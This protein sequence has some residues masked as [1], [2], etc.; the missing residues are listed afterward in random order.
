MRSC[1][2]VMSRMLNPGFSMRKGGT[3]DAADI[4]FQN[5]QSALSIQTDPAVRLVEKDKP[6]SAIRQGLVDPAGAM[7]STLGNS[8]ADDWDAVVSQKSPGAEQVKPVA[9]PFPDPFSSGIPAFEEMPDSARQ[10]QA[11]IDRDG[12]VRLPAG[13][14]FLEHPLHI[15]SRNRTEGILGDSQ[16]QVVL[17]AKGDFAIIEGRGDAHPSPQLEGS[18]VY[19]AF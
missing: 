6:A 8:R 5:V 2:C 19:L 4:L 3:G 11:D 12:I 9:R 13:R 15:G 17:I 16:G 1:N 14:Y 10:I 18:V 7:Q